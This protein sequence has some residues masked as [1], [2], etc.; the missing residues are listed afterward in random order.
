MLGKM[1]TTEPPLRSVS[2]MEL[3]EKFWGDVDSFKQS[4]LYVLEQIEESERKL[5]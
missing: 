3:Y 5:V 2:A 4:L 1:N